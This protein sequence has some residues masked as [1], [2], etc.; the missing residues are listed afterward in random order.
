MIYKIQLKSRSKRTIS[1]FERVAHTDARIT[2]FGELKIAVVDFDTDVDLL[3]C[4]DLD[5]KFMKNI[6]NKCKHDFSRRS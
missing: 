1:R 4:I 2:N 6:I 5:S 3:D